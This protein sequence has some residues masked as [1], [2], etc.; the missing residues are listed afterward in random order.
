MGLLLK[1]SEELVIYKFFVKNGK[2]FLTYLKKS[3]IIYCVCFLRNKLMC[4][5]QIIYK[6]KKCTFLAALLICVAIML[7]GCTEGGQKNFETEGSGQAVEGFDTDSLGES[8]REETEE[9]AVDIFFAP[10]DGYTAGSDELDAALVI[11]EKRLDSFGIKEYELESD[12]TSG[13]IKL[14]CL[15]SGTAKDLEELSASL[16]KKAELTFREGALFDLGILGEGQLVGNYEDLPVVLDGRDVEQATVFYDSTF[17]GYGIILEFN[18]GGTEKFSEVTKRLSETHGILSIYMDDAEL[19]RPVVTAHIT[20]GVATISGGFTAES[21]KELADK[22][23][24]GTLPFDMETLK[25][26]TDN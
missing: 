8:S 15:T 16:C 18:D 7:A 25:I 2:N 22:I 26:N 21:A 12:Y 24:S 23:N 19:C 17:S 5:E 13:Q 3:N 1:K 11:L 10:S 9:N 20:D 14:H 4:R 6:E